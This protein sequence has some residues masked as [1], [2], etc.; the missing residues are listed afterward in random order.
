MN[1]L[2]KP[3]FKIERGMVKVAAE[4]DVALEPEMEIW[5][6]DFLE[7]VDP[8]V[9]KGFCRRITVENLTVRT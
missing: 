2:E 8:A 1:E 5:H 4:A 3:K 7:D 9:L 6:D